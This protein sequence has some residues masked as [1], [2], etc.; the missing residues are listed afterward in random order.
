MS[1]PDTRKELIRLFIADDHPIVREGIKRLIQECSDMELVGE[2]A[3]GHELPALLRRHCVDVLLLDISMP[4]PGFRE[5]LK[6]ISGSCPSVRVLVLSMQPEK[7]YAT[8]ALLAGAAG[9]LAKD[10][11]AQELADAVRRVHLGDLYVSQKAADDMECDTVL[12]APENP[13]L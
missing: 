2:T 4:G 6:Q 8:R 7:I 5:T 3:D 10:R 1:N 11:S 9:Y 13:D 12:A